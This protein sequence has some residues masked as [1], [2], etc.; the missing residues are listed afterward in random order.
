MIEHKFII[1]IIFG[2]NFH[3]KQTIDIELKKKI[4]VNICFNHLNFAVDDSS[5]R[6]SPPAYTPGNVAAEG[7][8]ISDNFQEA[9]PFRP[10]NHIT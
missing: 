5:A 1:I 10:P 8:R 9:I 7:P 2:I 6:D 4:L 3:L